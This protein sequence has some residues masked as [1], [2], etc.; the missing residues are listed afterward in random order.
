MARS[1]RKARSA[2]LHPPTV[3]A[4]RTGGP[5]SDT[6]DTGSFPGYRLGPRS[7]TCSTDQVIPSAEEGGSVPVIK[8]P[9]ANLMRWSG[10]KVTRCLPASQRSRVHHS[11]RQ[12]TRT[13]KHEMG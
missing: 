9:F 4:A 11:A 2:W 10:D 6:A 8:G 12:R 5:R 1:L 3:P 13:P 7:G